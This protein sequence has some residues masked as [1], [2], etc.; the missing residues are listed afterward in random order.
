MTDKPIKAH[1]QPH[2]STEVLKPKRAK[3]LSSNAWF[4]IIAATAVV[5]FF[6]GMNSN[7][8]MSVIGP[9][10]GQKIYAGDIDLSSIQSTYHALKA[11]YDGNLNDKSL[12]EGANKGLVAAAGDAYTLYMNSAESTTFSDDLTGN[13]GGGIGA[14]I[15]L[16]NN[17]VY[18]IRVLKSNP[19]EKAGLMAGDVIMAVNDQSTAGWTV[20]KTVGQIRGNV[21]TTVKVTVLRGTDSKN[22]TI[23]RDTIT[24][25]SV[26]SSVVNGV[27]ILTISRFDSET[28]S[29]ARAAAQDFKTQGVKGVILDL[30]GDGGGYVDAAQDV[31]GLWLDGKVVV[32]EK[33]N[34]VVVSQLKS[35]SN[36]ILAGLTTIV[37][38]DSGTASASEIVSGALQDYKV[39]KLVGE[40]TF[41]KGSVQKL[42]SLPDGAELKVT[43][44]RWYTPS[45]KNITKE[46]ITPDVTAS[47]TQQNINDGVDPQMDAAKKALGL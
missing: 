31:A 9:V 27:G 18:I 11:N 12:I 32:T 41:G 22:F 15:G 1:V 28:S 17:Q 8:I 37:L 35:G 38:V 42:V 46:G 16:R 7:R 29:L 40:K 6:G 14:E 33:A 4:I 21:G 19:A 44:A 43:I 5:G 30:R 39:A 2:A 10:F 3:T 24:N 34:N 26:D 25:P 45:G 36:P 23:T 13:I 20:D 47:I